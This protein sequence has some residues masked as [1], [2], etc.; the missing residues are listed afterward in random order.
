MEGGVPAE[1]DVVG[2]ICALSGKFWTRVHDY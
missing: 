1:S 2:S